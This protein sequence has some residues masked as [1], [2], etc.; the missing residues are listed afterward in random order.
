MNDSVVKGSKKTKFGFS[1]LRRTCKYTAFLHG[2]LM[3]TTAI[4]RKPIC[5]Q[6]NE[7]LVR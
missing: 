4:S 1:C 6:L 2:Y 3:F 5:I 7:N